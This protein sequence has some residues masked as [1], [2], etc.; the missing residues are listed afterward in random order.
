M[1]RILASEATLTDELAKSSFAKRLS[2][3]RNHLLESLREIGKSGDL[4]LIVAIE[5]AIIQGDLDRYANSAGMLSSLKT[6]LLELNAAERH[7]TLVGNIAQY[8]QV[9]A[10][11]SLPKNRKA[12]LPW[13]EARQAFN[14]HYARLNNLDKSRL[15]DDEKRIIDARKSNIGN[16]DSLYAEQQARALGL[17]VKTAIKNRETHRDRINLKALI[18]AG[19]A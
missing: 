12:G 18:E 10:S 17:E 7:M 2:A 15:D 16:A 1:D 13:D 6:A 5:K 8:K 11:H 19:R 9:D 14:S 4:S 3:T